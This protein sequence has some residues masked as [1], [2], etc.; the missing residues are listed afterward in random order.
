MKKKYYFDVLQDYIDDD[1]TEEEVEKQNWIGNRSK[2]SM[3][4]K[5]KEQFCFQRRSRG[6]V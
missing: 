2:I 6:L 1:S 3:K 5:T 4:C